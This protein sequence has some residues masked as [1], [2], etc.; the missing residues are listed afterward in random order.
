MRSHSRRL[1]ERTW[2]ASSD[3]MSEMMVDMPEGDTIFRSAATLDR[4]I[5]RREVT[6]ARTT[7]DRLPAA[8]LVG[9]TVEGVE[10][11]GKH[12]LIRFD[13]GSVLHTHM[14]MTGSWHVYAAGERWQKPASQAR[15]VLECGD[16]V[17]VCFNAPVIELLAA[18]GEQQHPALRGL[19]PDVLKPPVD[20]V[21]VRRRAA[22]QPPELTVGELLLE[23]SVVAGIGNIWRC[24]S[25]FVR[26][27]N[28]WRPRSALGTA[29][30]DELVTVA[31]EL[32]QRS[33]RPTAYAG[34]DFGGGAD[35]P[36]VY[37]RARRPCYRC[38]TPI[39]R[40]LYGHQPRTVYW[41]PSCQAPA[42]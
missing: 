5:G 28:P 20:L 40:R 8:R 19:G 32:M 3:G 41:C 37:G 23:Q 14:K 31:S 27:M 15:L 25:L 29:E 6:A 30:L 12:L 38:R 21:E 16:R 18:K 17:A 35:R 24:E 36:W 42:A 11:Q 10:A 2:A 22:L 34:R 4:W 39:Q 9:R 1:T 33:A 26:R 13:G 7:V